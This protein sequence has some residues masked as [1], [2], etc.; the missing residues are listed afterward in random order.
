VR[1]TRQPRSEGAATRGASA[2][3]RAVCAGIALLMAPGAAAAEEAAAGVAPAKAPKKKAKKRDP[4][5]VAAAL[6]ERYPELIAR[7]PSLA[8]YPSL[9]A[10]KGPLEGGESSAILRGIARAFAEAPW[11]SVG[12]WQ[13]LAYI[14]A[15]EPAGYTIWREGPEL[16]APGLYQLG[17]MG[18]FLEATRLLWLPTLE[19]E[20]IREC[21]PDEAAGAV[22][23]ADES[24]LGFSALHHLKKLL[25]G[26]PSGREVA[27]VAPTTAGLK[28]L[29]GGDTTDTK[30]QLCAVSHEARA[31]ED[32]RYFHHVF[33]V[34]PRS[35]GDAVYLF[36]TT[37]KSGISYRRF[38]PASLSRYFRVSL[39]QNKMFRY[40]PKTAAL[41]CLEVPRPASTVPI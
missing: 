15:S 22:C 11:P 41:H 16:L 10:L 31:R 30:L 40:D 36:D 2:L 6:R 7:Y 5:R 4:E 8:H 32:R 12:K 3:L 28:A 38:S 33:V 23:D 20:Q 35:G 9:R 27:A 29:L 34:D 24:H 39:A 18:A 37:G 13:R 19:F 17:C 26:D 1:V 25:P 14:H 21:V